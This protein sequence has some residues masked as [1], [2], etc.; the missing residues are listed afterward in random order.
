LP[1][2]ELDGGALE[3]LPPVMPRKLICIG[4]NTATTTA[5]CSA[6]VEGATPY[7]FFKPPTTALVGSGRAISLPDHAEKSTTRPSSPW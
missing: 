6:R 3:W 4:A 5:R 2:R 1:A 7:S